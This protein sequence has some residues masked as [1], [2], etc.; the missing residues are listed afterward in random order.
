MKIDALFTGGNIHTLDDDH[1][2]ATTI[3]VH[4]GRIL[5]VD[6]DP[7]DFSAASVVDLAGATVVP[8][9]NDVHH[10][11]I[12]VGE[13]LK[14][15]DCSPRA[16]PTIKALQA[17]LR[18]AAAGLTPGSW[19]HGADI[20]QHAFGRWPTITEL[21]A[22]LPDHP[23]WIIHSS[24]HMGLANTHA[25]RL[26]GIDPLQPPLDNFGGGSF[27]V[28]AAGRATGL[29]TEGA[30]KFVKDAIPAQT[31]EDWIDSVGRANDLALS[32][33]LTSATDASLA[34][35]FL[36][37]GS[38]GG[39]GAYQEALKRGR[40]RL[41]MT[42]NPEANDLA[43]FTIGAGIG[44]GLITG[45]GDDRL[46]IG[47]VKF[48]ADGSLLGQTA[49]V[50][51]PFCTNHSHGEYAS[52]PDEFLSR[53]VAAHTAGWQ[54]SVHAI[55]DRAVDLTLRAY[56]EAQ[57]VHPRDGVRHR[58]EHAAITTEKDIERMV[59]LGVIPVPQAH[60]VGQFGDG[61]RAALGDERIP[62]T[63]RQKSFLDA[64]LVVPGSSDSPV[65]VGDPI[66]GIHDLVNRRTE[67]GWVF[68]E[69]EGIDVREALKNYT[70]RSAYANWDEN[71]RGTIAPGYLADLT[72]F[73]RDLLTVPDEDIRH[74]R[75]AMTVIGGE[76]VYER[77]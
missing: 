65:S 26:A 75:A 66:L 30:M 56:E 55:G 35:P 67:S 60:F 39:A 47:A 50:S 4:H 36:A 54:V 18:A 28:D 8:G 12:G 21:D 52:D 72:V 51:L 9:L 31:M 42:L 61:M 14:M 69:D 29:V 32:Y 24:G 40:L 48:Y 46:R 27:V 17:A 68:G 45:F 13:R 62:L 64:G 59:A 63:Y 73:D 43:D 15:V 5:A 2:H 16:T 10:H 22:A 23:L 74:V 76:V 1:P 57:R 71:D 38:R 11:L 49:A 53:V 25:L 37:D 77:A 7:G 70:V 20:D 3:A 6:P 34:G 33:G 58:M 19:V 44:Q 41:R